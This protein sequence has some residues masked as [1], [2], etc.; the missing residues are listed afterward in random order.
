MPSGVRDSTAADEAAL[1]ATYVRAM[2]ALAEAAL[3][4]LVGGTHALNHYL[5]IERSSKDFDVFVRRDEL[6]K[7]MSALAAAGF[8]TELTYPHWLGKARAPD[9]CVDVIFSSGNGVSTVDDAWF[10]HAAEG[11]AFGVPVKLS[12]A[13]EIIWSKAFIMERERYDGADVMHLILA[14][15]E[16]LDWARLVRRFGSHWRVL[17]AHL[18]LFGFMYPSERNRIPEWVMVGLLGRLD[19]ELRT[20]APTERITQG[21]LVSREQ[22]LPDLQVWGFKDARQTEVS[23]MTDDDIAHWTRA[24]Q[25]R[26]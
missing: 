19:R 8:T 10:E 22:Y 2:R 25:D 12:P 16:R 4:F 3:P 11:F 6:E 14:R 7:V 15:A 21:T 26:K 18:C 13:E 23:S 5:G 20:P 9:G 1:R 17:L 24:I